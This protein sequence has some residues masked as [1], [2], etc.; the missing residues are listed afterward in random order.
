MLLFPVARLGL[1]AVAFRL[2]AI[3]ARRRQ[4]MAV[5]EVPEEGFGL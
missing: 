4:L 1:G 5:G 2:F 3:V